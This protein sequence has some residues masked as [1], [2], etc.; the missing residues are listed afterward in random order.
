MRGIIIAAAMT[1]AACSDDAPNAGAADATDQ[2][3][4]ASTLGEQSEGQPA[5]AS[6]AEYGVEETA[7]AGP[8]EEFYSACVVGIYPALGKPIFLASAPVAAFLNH[9]AGDAEVTWEPLGDQTFIARVQSVNQLTQEPREVALQ[10]RQVNAPPIED[11]PCGP[12]AVAVEGMAFNGQE[13]A[14]R[15]RYQAAGEITT[16]IYKEMSA[17][18]DP[19]GPYVE[20]PSTE[21]DPPYTETILTAD[22]AIA[23]AL[24][25]R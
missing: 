10:L 23:A 21:N 18:T 6:G 11:R 17:S 7:Q 2:T 12:R 13:L 5:T 25:G 14:P 9:V 15:E 3:A 24:R 20:P 19:A 4:G 1:L 16:A 22:Q 8:A